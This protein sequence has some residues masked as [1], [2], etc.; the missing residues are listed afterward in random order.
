MHLNEF[1]NRRAKQRRKLS[2]HFQADGSAPVLHIGNVLPGNS[3]K[4]L[5]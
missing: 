2:G 5:A 1:F 4:G 3:T